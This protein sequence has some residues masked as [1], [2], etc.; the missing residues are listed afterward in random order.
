MNNASEK[1]NPSS[2]VTFLPRNL[3]SFSLGIPLPQELYNRNEVKTEK[4]EVRALLTVVAHFWEVLGI[5]LRC[6]PWLMGEKNWRKQLTPPLFFICSLAI[7][8]WG[9]R[10]WRRAGMGRRVAEAVRDQDGGGG[11]VAASGKTW[12]RGVEEVRPLPHETSREDAARKSGWHSQ[13]PRSAGG[14]KNIVPQATQILNVPILLVPMAQRSNKRIGLK[15]HLHTKWSDTSDLRARIS[16]TWPQS[17]GLSE[18]KQRAWTQ[19]TA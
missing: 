14:S 1:T 7:H 4:C 12:R 17:T 3:F 18:T 19:T 11:V 5:S 10:R 13:G 6:L 9:E 16:R 8:R 2:A 15:I